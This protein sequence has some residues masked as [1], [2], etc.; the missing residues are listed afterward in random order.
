[1]QRIQIA[2]G[3]IR[4]RQ[5]SL[6]LLAGEYFL[7]TTPS[8]GYQLYIGTGGSENYEWKSKEVK[9]ASNKTIAGPDGAYKKIGTT[10]PLGFFDTHAS[11]DTPG[12]LITSLPTNPTTGAVYIAKT[13]IQLDETQAA[14][15]E[16]ITSDGTGESTTPEIKRNDI[17]IYTGFKWVKINNAGG[18]ATESEFYNKVTQ[19]PQISGAANV[20]DAIVAL[21]S[22]KLAYAGVLFDSENIAK[23]SVVTLKSGDTFTFI[24][25]AT[26]DATESTTFNIASPAKSLGEVEGTVWLI[27]TECTINGVAYEQGDFLTVTATKA[28]SLRNPTS[29]TAPNERKLESGDVI[30]THV[31][32]G[33]HDPSKIYING[34]DLPR[35]EHGD[36][37]Y[38]T[39]DKEIK[40]VKE[41]LQV[42][43]RSKADLDPTTG[44]LLISQLPDTIIGAMEYQGTYN[45]GKAI[46]DTDAT[47]LSD[48]SKAYAGFELPT[49]A[50]K[51]S[52]EVD[53]DKNEHDEEYL[54]K[55]DYWI[56][57]SQYKWDITDV[58]EIEASGIPEYNG[59]HYITNG[60]WIVYCGNNKW[61]VI[62][63][64]D[65]FTGIR[66]ADSI[67]QGTVKFEGNN[68]TEDIAETTVEVQSDGQTVRI[69]SPNAILTKDGAPVNV[70]Y[71]SNSATDKTAVA[72]NLTDDGTDLTIKETEGIKLTTGE[73]DTTVT[74]TII[75]NNK[76]AT[77]KLPN[78]DTTLAGN[79]DLGIVD[80]DNTEENKKRGTDWFATMYRT[81]NNRKVIRDS[82][83]KFLGTEVDDKYKLSG[84]SLRDET[85]AAHKVDIRLS[86]D[87]GHTVQVLPRL[88]G[89][90][91]NS[92]SILDCGVWNSDHPT[93]YAPTEGYVSESDK[94][95]KNRVTYDL[96]NDTDTPDKLQSPEEADENDFLTPTEREEIEAIITND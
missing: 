57:A 34:A 40:N 72:S 1:M 23:N 49:V 62:D 3:E 63:N 16:N 30:L 10:N 17:I 68:R 95:Y 81:E 38:G 77:V 84:I 39:S 66:V 86:S 28:W 35:S 54:V 52:K 71:K 89:Y 79:Q 80:A 9:D 20:Q 55:G 83:L 50:N 47:V 7:D 78:I 32:G 96:E 6:P 59:K 76:A 82:F 26:A 19:A 44:K 85:S 90:L 29:A 91:L 2:R 87:T 21:D 51:L 33:T 5:A 11:H 25:K 61:A 70:I 75:G 14:L 8:S 36:H 12:Y 15:F 92:N 13:N 41:A 27:N 24:V 43:F 94:I 18:S 58:A 73:G 88:S 67:M 31:P 53:A 48:G 93:G 42:A 74:A 4:V 65:A 56:F 46:T 22:Q 45:G 60:D 69:S 37:V 64:S